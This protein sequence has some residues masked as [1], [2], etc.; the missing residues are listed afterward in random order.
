MKKNFIKYI[1]IVLFL[2]I[3]LFFC[4]ILAYDGFVLS[5]DNFKEG[6]LYISEI[7]PINKTIIFDE[8][9][10]YSDY[11]EIYNSSDKEINLDGFFL[12]D[13]LISSKK[14]S[15]PKLII[16]PHEYLV[17]FASGKDKCN[18]SKRICHTNFKLDKDGETIT[19]LNN[20][21]EIINK[22]RYSNIKQDESF[23]YLN[24]KYEITIGTPNKENI[25]ETN[26]SNDAKDIIINEVVAF[27]K[28]A[29]ELKNN[30]NN[31]IELK[32]YSIGD[33]FGTKVSLDGLVI[34]ANSYVVIY[35]SD[36]YSY[37]NGT[38]YTG[39]HIGS[40]NEVIYLY[41][42][43]LI[44]DEFQVGRL[45]NGVSKGI[46]DDKYVFYNNITL[47]SANDCNYYLGYANEPVFLNDKVYVDIGTKV[48]LFTNDNSE[49]FY[50]LDGSMPTKNSKKYSDDIIIN[51]TTVIRA[52]SYKEGYLPSEVVS[53]TY[54]VGREHSLPIISIS[55]ND[56]DLYGNDGIFIKG[57]NAESFRP[58]YGANYW[59][60]VELPISFELY[61]DGKLGIS[62]NAGLKV[63]GGWSR[64]EAQ[65]SVAIYL[66]EEYGLK[67]I[68]YPF[69]DENVNRFSKFILRSGGQDFGKL[70]IKD[71]FL[72]EC[73]TGQMDIDKQD[74]RP[75]VVY[76]NGKYHGLYNI[77]EKTDT[78]YVERHY[79][80]SKE[81]IDF[82]ESNNVVKAG[83]I[84]SYNQLLNYVNNN[85]MKSEEVYKYLETQIDMQE[86]ANYWVTVTYFDQF[87]PMNI[88]FYKAKENGKW[89]WILFDLDQT[90]FGHSY[91]YI[92]WNLP[93]DPYA[94]GNG[95]YLNTTLMSRLIQNP[96]FRLLYIETFAY[97][98]KNTFNPD[99]II[100]IL[101]RMVKEIEN[102]MPY[103]ISRWYNESIKTSTYTLDN[104]YEWYNNIEFFK[105]QLVVR[106][107]VAL[108]TIKSGLN[109]TDD[110]YNKYFGNW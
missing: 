8:D 43:D 49:I 106:Y 100:P 24:N 57:N 45:I 92:K 63:F 25:L 65:K 95:Y 75:V 40:S 88:K 42:E 71:A 70:K 37:T 64:V 82:I 90:F 52:I 103:H 11:I 46:V 78:S 41:K 76:I 72:Q 12:T 91:S 83:S 89:R 61:E 6:A 67:E 14:W 13:E 81:E 7:V 39:F 29:I 109:L 36:D 108:N 96:K 21:G 23:S 26:Y 102:E 9:N 20:K 15:F 98:L 77:R 10:E 104:I 1:F 27:D 30:T 38:L 110:E 59:K 22:V 32:N 68:V 105:N 48:S 3:T 97:H 31:D 66:R 94:H 18:L 87:D 50:T 101:D 4:I 74:Y 60:D 99:R 47:G 79:G 2:F 17:V 51:N 16:R 62:F 54:F 53:R 35:G 56:N 107:K 73:L 28:E 33:K 86:L 93:F 34:K 85:D 58:Y 55:T 44:I 80:Y 19:L 5:N 84:D 69:F